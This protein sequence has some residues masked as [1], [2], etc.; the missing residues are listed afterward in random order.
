MNNQLE[1]IKH[2]ESDYQKQTELTKN[3]SDQVTEKESLLL[4][5]EKNL[6]E[7]KNDNELLKEAIS[8]QTS[9]ARRRKV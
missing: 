7:L 8:I 1:S 3:L 4:R 5:V 9:D 2:F 6:E